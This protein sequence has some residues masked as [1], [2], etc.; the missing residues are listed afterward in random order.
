MRNACL[1]RPLRRIQQAG[2]GILLS[3]R[4]SYTAVV[5]RVASC[6]VDCEWVRR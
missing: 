4:K 5:Y 3:V 1:C 6:D 2:P